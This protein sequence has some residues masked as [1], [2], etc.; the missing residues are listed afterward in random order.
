MSATKCPILEIP[1]LQGQSLCSI[2]PLKWEDTLLWW[3]TVLENILDL[4]N[5]NINVVITSRF[6]RWRFFQTSNM[7]KFCNSIKK[8]ILTVTKNSRGSK[9]ISTSHTVL[10]NKG[11]SAKCNHWHLPSYVLSCKNPKNLNLRNV[12][13]NPSTL[14][15]LICT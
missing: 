9:N 7:R 10:Q 12:T 1:L 3:S 2:C 15:T 8:I 5:G 6:V 14:I 4:K 11:L 13:Q